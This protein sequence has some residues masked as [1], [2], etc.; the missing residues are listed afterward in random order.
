MPQPRSPY[1]LAALA[2]A[3]LLASATYSTRAGA[4]E[5]AQLQPMPPPPPPPPGSGAP[6]IIINYQSPGPQYQAPMY[7]QTQPSYVPQSAAMSGPR[8]ITDWD[9][10]RPVPP[11]YHP[12][13]RVRKG[14]I[15]GGACTFGAMYLFTTLGAAISSDAGS[16]ANA[17][18]IPGVGP[19]VQMAQ[20]G[21]ATGTFLLAVDGIAQIGGIA[22]F[23]VGLAAPKTVLVRNDLGVDLHFVPVV[24]RDRQGVALMGT[25]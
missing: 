5:H 16:P 14:L 20:G 17:L 2:A 23:A 22:M 12:E 3:C 7:Q 11:G 15:I 10:D 25:F 13:E 18:Y 24:A 21:S 8:V 4:Q 6:P 1:S 9:S 19:F